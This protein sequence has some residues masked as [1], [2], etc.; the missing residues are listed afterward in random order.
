[1]SR[2]EGQTHASFKAHKSTEIAYIKL[3]RTRLGHA[4]LRV[5][6]NSSRDS[7]LVQNLSAVGQNFI[8]H[9]IAASYPSLARS[10][11]RSLPTVDTIPFSREWTRPSRTPSWGQDTYVSDPSNVELCFEDPVPRERC[12]FDD[13]RLATGEPKRYRAIPGRERCSPRAPRWA[14]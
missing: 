9:A 7:G 12:G 2:F 3:S 10:T 1:M 11:C 6:L 13:W 14:P 5:R 8:A 4:T